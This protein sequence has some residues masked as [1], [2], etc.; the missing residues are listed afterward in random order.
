MI[1]Y[2]VKILEAFPVTHDVK[3]FRT[4]KPAGFDFTPGQATE[5]F[6]DDPDWKE[7]GRPFTFTNLPDEEYLEFTIKGY[8][9]HNGVTEQIHKLGVGDHFLVSEVFGAIHYQ[10][11]GLFIAGGAGITPFISI[12]RKMNAEG[13]LGTTGLIFGNKTQ[14]DIILHDELKEMLGDRMVNV[15]SDESAEGF[16]SGMITR[17]LIVD[18]LKRSHEKVYVCGPPKMMEAVLGH[19]EALEIKGDMIVKEEV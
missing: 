19:L 15:L 2:K 7:E 12:L 3:S 10:G 8:P 9:E 6:L 18:H 1:K 17:E 5:V 13:E 4:E 16:R 14:A 11:E